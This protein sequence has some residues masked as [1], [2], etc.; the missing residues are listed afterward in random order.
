[1][2]AHAGIVWNVDLVVQYYS[3]PPNNWDLETI[4]RNIL[5][6]LDASRTYGSVWDPLSVMHYPMKRGFIISPPGYEN[7]FDRAGGLSKLDKEWIYKYYPGLD[8][9]SA[10]MLNVGSEPVSVEPSWGGEQFNFRIVP[11]ETKKYVLETRG[12]ADTLLVLQRKDENG[13]MVKVAADDDSGTDSNA[14][15]E[16]ELSA[17]VTYY[18]RMRVVFAPDGKIDIACDPA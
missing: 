16:V 11:N 17:G 18:L 3:G 8:S 2:S 4:K 5:D 6:K 7:G 14:R 15:L 1:M 9:D 13:E 12:I 10:R